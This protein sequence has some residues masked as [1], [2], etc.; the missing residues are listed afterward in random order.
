MWCVLINLHSRGPVEPLGGLE[1]RVARH[2][3]H[4]ELAEFIGQPVCQA[5]PA[6]VV[7]LTFVNSGPFLNLL[8]LALILFFRHC[9]MLSMLE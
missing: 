1:A 5:G 9:N 6:E 8:E 2:D 3:H 7:K 4:L